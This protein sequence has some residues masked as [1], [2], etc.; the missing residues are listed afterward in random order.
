MKNKAYEIL[1]EV[2]DNLKFLASSGV[3]SKIMLSLKEGPKNLSELREGIVL[4]SST[5]LHGTNELEKRHMVYKKGDRYILSPTGMILTL[6][7]IDMVQSVAVAKKFEKLWNGHQID[8]IPED[9]ILEIGSLINSSLI[10]S[11]PTDIFLTHTNFTEI[12]SNS[13]KFRGISPFFHPEFPNLLIAL[14][15]KG[16]ET[17]LIVTKSIMNKV[18]ELAAQD[19]ET[20]TKISSK[21]NFEVWLIEEDVKLA[22]TVNDEIVSFGLALDD[23]TYDYSMDLVS[24]D[25][26]AILWGEKL[27]EY[28]LKKSKK[29]V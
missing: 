29:I 16:V 2:Q 12:L 18:Y 26:D 7:L 28:Y 5:I 1:D 25:H 21:E 15:S 14:V 3:R 19:P 6:K 22:L 13:K 24:D 11:E 4:R 27:F 17:Q 10:E 8:S 23:G 9:L 20:F